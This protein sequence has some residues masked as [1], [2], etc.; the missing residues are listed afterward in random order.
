MQKKI[1][2]FINASMGTSLVFILLGLVFI[3]WPGVSLDVIRWIISISALAL[4]AYFIATDLSREHK[5]FS[6]MNESMLGTLLVILGVVFAVN[7]GVMTIFPV[8]LG[9][10]FVVSAVSACRVTANLKGTPAYASSLLVAV[11]SMIAG[12]VLIINP[13]AGS[14]M[15]MMFVGIIIVVYA[16]SSFIDMVILKKNLKTFEKKVKSAVADIKEAEVKEEKK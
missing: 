7:P 3:L 12:I 4:G 11:L 1:K 9:A 8:V 14:E 5:G 16:L 6:L 13:W 10:W 2:S 15:M